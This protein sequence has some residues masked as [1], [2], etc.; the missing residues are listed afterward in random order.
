MNEKFKNEIELLKALKDT[1]QGTSTTEEA[2][3]AEVCVSLVLR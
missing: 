2:E 3:T 1:S